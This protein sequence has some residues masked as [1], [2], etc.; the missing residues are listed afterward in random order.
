MS[1]W[2]FNK[3]GNIFIHNLWICENIFFFQN[4]L[5]SNVYK[6]K[7]SILVLDETTWHIFRIIKWN[8]GFSEMY[9][10]NTNTKI[11]MFL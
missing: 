11:T 3:K 8:E 5:Y 4:V 2:Y 7:E 6:C 9:E 1:H 10:N